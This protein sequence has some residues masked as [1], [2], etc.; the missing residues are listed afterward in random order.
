MRVAAEAHRD[1]GLFSRADV[2]G[3]IDQVDLGADGGREVAEQAKER[4]Q[5]EGEE[6]HGPT[7]TVKPA[8]SK[9]TQG[10]QPT[11][12]QGSRAASLIPW[13][14]FLSAGQK[15]ARIPESSVVSP[16]TKK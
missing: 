5:T 7:L 8:G 14:I 13:M 15:V 10:A 1:E 9:A 2:G 12:W 6:S 3:Q 4:E 16:S 11:T